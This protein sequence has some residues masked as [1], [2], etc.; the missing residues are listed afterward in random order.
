MN[1]LSLIFRIWFGLVFHGKD[2]AI[3]IHSFHHWMSGQPS[4]TGN[5]TN[6]LIN[7][8]NKDV[9]LQS[10]L[11]DYITYYISQVCFSPRT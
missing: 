10:I 7:K 3:I 5:F 1:D 6:S 11:T 9:L 2:T 8:M 4:D